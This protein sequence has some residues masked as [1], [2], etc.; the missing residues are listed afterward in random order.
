MEFWVFIFDEIILT[1]RK[2]WGQTILL[3]Q[4]ESQYKEGFIWLSETEE[5]TDSDFKLWI[6]ETCHFLCAFTVYVA[7]TKH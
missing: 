2:L 4:P 6:F 1:T 3:S 7:G 5:I